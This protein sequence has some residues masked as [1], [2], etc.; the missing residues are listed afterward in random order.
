VN[1]AAIVME[2]RD[3]CLELRILATPRHR[4]HRRTTSWAAAVVLALAANA[5]SGEVEFVFTPEA[6]TPQEAIDGFEA[7]GEL[8][9]AR[10][11]DDVVLRVDI[12]FKPLDPGVLGATGSE[13]ITATYQQLVTA[14][15]AQP[16]SADDQ[17]AAAALQ[18]PPARRFLLNRTA[19]SPHGS[20]DATPFLDEDGDA[21]NTT[22]RLTRA[23]AKALGLLPASDPA[24]DASISFSS[25]FNWDFT[26]G[27]GIAL[28]HFNFVFVAAHEIGHMLGFTSGVDILDGNSPPGAGPFNDTA[29]TWANTA[30]VFRFSAASVAEGAG[31]NDW[32]AD[33]RAKFFSLDG[34]ATNL[35]EFSRGRRFGDGQQASH[36]RDNLGLGL[37]DPTAAPGEVLQIT[38]LD[39]RLF[40]AIGW[41]R[42][43]VTPPVVVT[44]ADLAIEVTPDLEVSFTIVARNLGPDAA[45]D[46]VVSA[47]LPASVVNVV[48]QCTASP[49]ASCTA[50]GIGPVND[51]VDLQPGASA[52]YVAT[53]RLVGIAADVSITPAAGTSDP[54]P[55]NNTGGP[56][57]S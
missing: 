23:N 11:D 35:G 46:A 47:S 56:G 32:C 13:R 2:S 24:L 29:F 12:A 22:L 7:A 30:D 25:D 17:A 54:N 43:G 1:T 52:R 26:P 3:E 16:A 4:R 27:D 34:G 15:G 9:S 31:V 48:W 49:G 40:D 36:W 50:S 42:V 14:L 5:A 28:N 51:I 38:E 18:A 57:P 6:G 39:L 53:G 55:G 19:N 33:N 44:D 41:E 21:N 20:G 37:L 8:W 45:V 10:L